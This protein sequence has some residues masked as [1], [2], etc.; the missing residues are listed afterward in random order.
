MMI[1]W[2]NIHQS[3]SSTKETLQAESESL[4]GKR[5]WSRLS[6]IAI[7]ETHG[8][9]P[10]GCYRCC[11]R[12]CVQTTDASLLWNQHLPSTISV[13]GSRPPQAVWV[14]SYLVHWWWYTILGLSAHKLLWKHIRS[15]LID[16]LADLWRR[17]QERCGHISL[18]EQENGLHSSWVISKHVLWSMRKANWG[19][20]SENGQRTEAKTQL[21]RQLK[22]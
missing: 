21:N 9:D 8:K 2:F 10:A 13:T 5:W 18:G 16:N 19:A 20:D 17:K 1:W 11:R 12:L 6:F 3:I 4:V 7:C 22:M 15:F 14:W